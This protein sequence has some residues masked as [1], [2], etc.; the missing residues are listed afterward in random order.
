MQIDRINLKKELLSNALNIAFSKMSSYGYA[1]MKLET[2]IPNEQ[3]L[4][5]TKIN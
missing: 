1:Y 2:T 3:I 4:K 5:Y